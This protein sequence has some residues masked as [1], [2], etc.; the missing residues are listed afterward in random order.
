MVENEDE[1]GRSVEGEQMKRRMRQLLETEV[2]TRRGR[3]T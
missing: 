1:R 2:G 3:A